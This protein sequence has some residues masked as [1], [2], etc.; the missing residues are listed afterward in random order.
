M[1]NFGD[2]VKAVR[3]E[4]GLNQEALV[5]RLGAGFE[6]PRVSRLEKGTLAASAEVIDKM[7][8]VFGRTGR[9]LAQGTDREGHYFA[10]GMSPDERASER[11]V[12]ARAVEILERI[13]AISV[14]MLKNLLRHGLRPL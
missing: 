11:D 3:K 12:Q 9:E 2:R 10:Q 7:A 6:Q 5:N 8:A 1:V 4:L 14:T 13:K